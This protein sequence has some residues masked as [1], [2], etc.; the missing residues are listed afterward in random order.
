MTLVMGDPSLFGPMLNRWLNQSVG[1]I[2]LSGCS[3][4][5]TD[6]FFQHVELN[7]KAGK[8]KLQKIRGLI[9]LQLLTQVWEN[10]SSPSYPRC[11]FSLVLIS[12]S[13][14]FL[15]QPK[16]QCLTTPVPFATFY[17]THSQLD[18]ATLR[19]H[20]VWASSV[21]MQTLLFT[22]CIATLLGLLVSLF[23]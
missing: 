4:D 22:V 6:K 12:A 10:P 8:A 3:D 18:L 1:K 23:V 17:Q 11:G 5:W 2:T 13:S 16:D 7:R 15:P 9:Y 14:F 21:K 19:N 20:L